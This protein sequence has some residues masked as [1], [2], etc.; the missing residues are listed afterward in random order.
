[1]SQCHPAR[2]GFPEVRG[3]G[4]TVSAPREPVVPDRDP[5][6]SPHTPDFSGDVAE[7]APHYYGVEHR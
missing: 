5:S 1:M 7:M 4:G 3:T 2:C 6:G